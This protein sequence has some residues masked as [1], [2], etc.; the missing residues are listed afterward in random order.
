MKPI[1]WIAS[2]PKSGNTWFRA[3][4][5]ALIGRELEGPILDELEGGPIASSME[6]FELE[7]GVD[8]SELTVSEI[9]FIRPDVFRSYAKRT[10]EHLYL[11][12]HDARID[13]L[14]NSDII[15][16]DATQGAIYLIRNPLD[17]AVSWANHSGVTIEKS[18][19]SLI[20]K[21]HTLVPLK[22]RAYG[23]QV[24][25]FIGCWS[26]HVSSWTNHDRFATLV[27]RYEDL[28]ADPAFHFG[29]ATKFLKIEKTSED[30]EKAVE[31]TRFDKLQKQEAEHGFSE[32][33]RRSKQFFRNGK[34]GS[35]HEEL[36]SEWADR[37][38][39]AHSETMRKFGY[40]DERGK[41]VY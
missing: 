37:I 24:P 4:L 20:D 1:S 35:W 2:Y 8:C 39:E 22:D 16:P 33:P 31:A 7:A 21:K 34:A 40:I 23:N 29:R 3:F 10:P 11:K 26:N 30:I 15:P 14:T 28:L 9:Q 19:R 5:T 17:I 6:M 41:P 36:P 12:I 18:A 27:L 25:Q 32:R 13:K 38:I